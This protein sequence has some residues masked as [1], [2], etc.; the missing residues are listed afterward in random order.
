MWTNLMLQGRV[1]VG[2]QQERRTQGLKG[3]GDSCKQTG[4]AL[5]W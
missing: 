2:R 5:S 1:R 3:L 4:S